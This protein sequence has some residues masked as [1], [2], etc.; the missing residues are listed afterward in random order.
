MSEEKTSP[1]KASISVPVRDQPVFDTNRELLMQ[2]LATLGRK[3]SFSNFVRLVIGG[4][5]LDKRD[6]GLYLVVKL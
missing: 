2:E 1:V 3:M 4:W 5:K 6:D